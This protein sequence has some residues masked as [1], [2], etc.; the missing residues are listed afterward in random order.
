MAALETIQEPSPVRDAVRFWIACLVAPLAPWFVFTCFTSFS[1]TSFSG[2]VRDALWSLQL[3]AIVFYPAF[4]LLGLPLHFLFRKWGWKKFF[5]YA[6]AG[7]VAGDAVVAGFGF[8]HDVGLLELGAVFGAI[9][10]S[11]FWL[12][13]RPD[14]AWL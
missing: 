9:A 1:S 8:W 14:R 10:A 3:F 4:F 13:A 7:L 2:T 6:L 5:A 11:A 12:I